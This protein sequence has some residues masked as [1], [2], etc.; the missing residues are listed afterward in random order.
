MRTAAFRLAPTSWRPGKRCL[1]AFAIFAAATALVVTLAC[2]PGLDEPFADAWRE[3]RGAHVAV[4]G[5]LDATRNPDAHS[6]PGVAPAEA[7]PRPDVPAPVAGAT[8]DI[9]LGDAPG[10]R[11]VGRPKSPRA[12]A[13]SRLRGPAS[14]AA[15]PAK[16]GLRPARHSSTLGDP[17]VPRD[18]RPRRHDRSRSTYPRWDPGLVWARRVHTRDRRAGRRPPQRPRG[19][20]RVQ[21]RGRPSAPPRGACSSP[22][23][24]RSATRSPIRPVPTR[25][26]S[27]ST[28]CSPCSRSASP[29]R[30]SSA[31]ACSPSG[32]SRPDQGGRLLAPHIVALLVAESL[33]SPLAAGLLGLIAGAAIAPLLLKPMSSLL[34][35]PTLRR[36]PSRLPCS[37]ARADPCSPS[38]VFTA[39]PALRAVR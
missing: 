11:R 8:V 30:R 7:R 39:I 24:T 16:R 12:G 2:A 36:F 32:A 27:S 29:S 34:A 10:S 15:S 19:H 3:T 23:G 14:S 33:R 21:G 38:L 20:R 31:A 5:E 26:S 13:R 4:Y 37:P 28:R 9:G 18:R 6:L 35:T 1:T 17:A 22:T 25:W